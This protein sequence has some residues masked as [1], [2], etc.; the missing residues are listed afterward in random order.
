MRDDEAFAR[1]ARRALERALKARAE[2]VRQLKN[3]RARRLRAGWG[4]VAEDIH[5]KEV[6]R[7]TA[8]KIASDAVFRRLGV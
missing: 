6:A 5:H 7:L 3:A 1:N 2:I 4:T 8:L